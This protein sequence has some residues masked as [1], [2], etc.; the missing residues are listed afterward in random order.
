VITFRSTVGALEGFRA[1][2]VG[3]TKRIEA[4]RDLLVLADDSGESYVESQDPA[5]GERFIELS[6]Q[7][8]LGS[9]TS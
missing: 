5:E 4:V 7:I 8:D 1:E 3:E 2:T 9:P 6:K